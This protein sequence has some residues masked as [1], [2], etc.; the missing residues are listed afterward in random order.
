MSRIS[1]ANDLLQAQAASLKNLSWNKA[2][3]ILG[4]Q[5]GIAALQGFDST[6]AIADKLLDHY[7]PASSTEEEKETGQFAIVVAVYRFFIRLIDSIFP[8]IIAAPV[9]VEEDKLLHSVQTVGRLSNKAARRVYAS[10][11]QHVKTIS[12]DDLKVYI[13]NIVA[14]LHLTQYLHAINEK[15]Q[16][17]TAPK[18]KQNKT[19]ASD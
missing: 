1:Y 2:N 11:R 13:S 16:A 14:I 6:A 4:T 7:F 5:F 10:V 17:L 9:S 3:D 18:E 19:E 8:F 12:A 15:V